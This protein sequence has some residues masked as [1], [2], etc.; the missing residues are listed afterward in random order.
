MVEMQTK[1]SKLEPQ[2]S[3]NHPTLNMNVSLG[4]IESIFYEQMWTAD[5]PKRRWEIGLRR[6][7]ARVPWTCNN[8]QLDQ[9][10][11]GMSQDASAAFQHC[12]LNAGSEVRL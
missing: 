2:L 3:A 12:H 1:E 8:Q 10:E 4:F 9:S 6:Y 11:R 5:F 7:P